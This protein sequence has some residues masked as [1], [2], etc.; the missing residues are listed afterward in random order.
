MMKLLTKRRASRRRGGQRKALRESFSLSRGLSGVDNSPSASNTSSTTSTPVSR[1]FFLVG[2][3]A[4]VSGL[5]LWRPQNAFGDEP[6][7]DN[8][9]IFRGNGFHYGDIFWDCIGISEAGNGG[10]LDGVMYTDRWVCAKTPW[11][12]WDVSSKQLIRTAVKLTMVCDFTTE[13]YH[14]L[15]GRLEIACGSYNENDLTYNLWHPG[16][17]DDTRFSLYSVLYNP[18]GQHPEELVQSK[19]IDIDNQV[20]EG[21]HTDTDTGQIWTDYRSYPGSNDYNLWVRRYPWETTWAFQMRAWFWNYYY[22][23]TGW[24]SGS[25]E[26]HPMGYSTQW[27]YQRTGQTIITSNK[28]WEHRIVEIS[29]SWSYD[30]LLDASDSRA[31]NGTSIVLWEVLN[32]T[33]QNWIILPSMCSSSSDCVRV[34][35][36][37]AGNY[38][39]T[40]DHQNGGPTKGPAPAILWNNL[41]NAGQSFWLCGGNSEFRLFAD[42]S[43]LAL[44]RVNG[45]FDNGTPIQFHSN[46]Y[47]ASEW[48]NQSHVWH[49]RDATFRTADGGYLPVNGRVDETVCEC[50]Q[51]LYAADPNDVCVPRTRNGDTRPLGG[52]FYENTWVITDDWHGCLNTNPE[53]MGTASLNRLGQLEEQPGEN[54]IGTAA[55]GD[56]GLSGVSLRVVN[57][58]VA[59]GVEFKSSGSPVIN[60]FSISLTGVLNKW[61]LAKYRAYT[62]W[63]SWTAWHSDGAWLSAGGDI[64]GICAVIRPRGSVV[65][66]G[67]SAS[68][69]TPNKEQAN[70]FVTCYVRAK[71]AYWEIPYRGAAISRSFKIKNP[72]VQIQFFVDGASAPVYEDET[73]KGT[74]YYTPQAAKRAGTKQNCYSFEGWYTNKECTV[75]FSEGSSTNSD[76]LKL[77]G[78]NTVQ[79]TYALTTPTQQMF[80]DHTMFLDSQL[81]TQTS[82]SSVVP[83]TQVLDWGQTITI[84]ARNSLWYVDFE[85]TREATPVQGAFTNAEEKGTT[86]KAMRLTSNVQLYIAWKIAQ[87]DG[88]KVL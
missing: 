76:E 13:L 1:R 77:Y 75:R 56:I 55:R 50:K 28:A 26:K 41:S 16:S 17:G 29:P 67:T 37:H 88:V 22:Y 61:F 12:E 33:S 72:Y 6:W 69:F 9:Y 5:L 10:W 78:K 18:E 4:C 35:P 45:S 7:W 27:L 62:V 43:G 21:I 8:A 11:V 30:K 49:L 42:C 38:D 60:S 81:T 31:F 74:S 25:G 14:H 53:I 68:S 2:G 32:Q 83:E 15:N 87:F 85:Q 48:D 3:A 86:I 36:V 19:V 71:A 39:F 51:T 23:G 84:S 80:A 57:S 64:A 54:V 70:K 24:Y 66:E 65:A 73:R 59:G 44:D 52:I 58:M 34:R 46:G 40:L 47:A 82:T 63:G 79:V 20:G